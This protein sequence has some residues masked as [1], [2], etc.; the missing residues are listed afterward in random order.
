M[1]PISALDTI[2]R[3]LLPVLVMGFLGTIA[4]M[5]VTGLLSQ[6]MIRRKGEK[7]HE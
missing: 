2:Q 7:S 3:M 1:L 6:W 5:A 4:V